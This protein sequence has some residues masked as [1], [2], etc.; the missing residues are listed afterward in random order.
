ML[1]ARQRGAVTVSA[2]IAAIVFG[3][4]VTHCPAAPEAAATAGPPPFYQWEYQ[5]NWMTGQTF[6]YAIDPASGATIYAGPDGVYY[7]FLHAPPITPSDLSSKW[8]PE[9]PQVGL[10]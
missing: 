2:V 10:P 6:T 5:H 4:V 3:I 9:P 7:E 8:Q 1:N